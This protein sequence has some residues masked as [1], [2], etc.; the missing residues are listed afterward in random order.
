MGGGCTQ[1]C[2]MFI[3]ALGALGCAGAGGEGDC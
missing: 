3:V 1:A 2:A